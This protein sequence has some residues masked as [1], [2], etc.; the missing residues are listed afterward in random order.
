V[1]YSE[2]L[3][4][5]LI[6]TDRRH[7]AIGPPDPLGQPYRVTVEPNI[8]APVGSVGPNVPP[9][10]D[11]SAQAG[12]SGGYGATHVIYPSALPPLQAQA[13]AGWPSEWAV[14]TEWAGYGSAALLDV[15]F[16]AIDRN[17]SAF[18]SMP[19]SAIKDGKRIPDQ[20]AWTR[21]PLAPI[22]SS[23]HEFASQLWW[24]YQLVG[25]AFV[26]AVDYLATG[27]PAR[28]MVV[29]PWLV[30]VTLVEGIREYSVNGK[31]VTDDM[32][33]I[34]YL[35]TA[36][37]PH[38]HAPLEAGLGKVLTVRALSR[39]ATDLAA[40]GGIPWGVLK[41]KYRL[42]RDQAQELKIQWL[43]AAATRMGAPA[44]LDN[45]TDLQVTQVVPKDMQLVELLQA[46]EA[47]LSVLLLVPPYML[48]L[49]MAAGT[50]SITYANVQS[51]Y[52][53]HYRLLRTKIV[54]IGGALGYW[55]LP[56]LTDLEF[57]AERYIQLSAT[58]RASYY[59]A[60]HNIVDNNGVRA[61]TVEEIRRTE[62]IDLLGA[63]S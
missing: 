26:M 35:S 10:G 1:A 24:N 63:P 6:V 54:Q 55:A 25:E 40:S 44:V 18:A 22:Y 27:K 53:E 58:D 52:D 36:D 23:W 8:N 57:D 19:P 11:A 61:M 3:P 17:A 41:T 4:S 28:M 56:N 29:P 42:T 9:A 14:P 12:E 49:P 15:V 37:D 30:T 39:Y 33:H 13:W 47:R 2:R 16:A 45:E 51:I 31:S 21:Q 46:A 34:R 48:A 5:G 38:G 7:R 43:E 60:M 32:C 62:R 59:T 50:A 20:P